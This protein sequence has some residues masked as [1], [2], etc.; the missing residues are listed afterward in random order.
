MKV[1]N[2]TVSAMTHGLMAGRATVKRSGA[3]GATVAVAAMQ[4]PKFL[5]I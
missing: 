5:E 4:N 3:V 2:V 1:A